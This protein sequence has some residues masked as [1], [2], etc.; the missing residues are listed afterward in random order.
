MGGNPWLYDRAD[1]VHKM[2]RDHA[3]E[4]DNV[5]KEETLALLAKNSA[6]A[7]AA[8]RALS[9]K[10]LDSAALASLYNNAPL[11]CQFLLEDHAVRHSYHHLAVIR[12]ALGR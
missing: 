11:T 7:A 6:A 1:T 4:N 5:T 12:K 2:N 10:E 9:D 3:K 8:I